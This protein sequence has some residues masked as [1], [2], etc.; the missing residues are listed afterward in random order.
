MST[1]INDLNDNIN[2]KWADV[3]ALIKAAKAYE[4][5]DEALYDVICRS[6]ILFISAH[7]ESFVKDAAK[8]AIN[9]IN[10][11][12]NFKKAPENIKKIYCK[13][14]TH[15]PTVQNISNLGAHNADLE[16]RTLKLIET[17]NDFDIKFTV[18]PFLINNQYGNNQKNPTPN[19]ISKVFNN[20]GIKNVFNWLTNSEFE[21]LFEGTSSASASIQQKLDLLH[22]HIDKQ[23]S[24]FPYT[25][26]LNIINI[27]E[28]SDRLTP[29]KIREQRSFWETFLDELL[30]IRHKIAHGSSLEEGFS[31]DAIIDYKQ[32][33]TILEKMLILIL[34]HKICHSHQ[35]PQLSGD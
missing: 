32:K 29:S 20:F 9:D 16:Q 14:F 6:S 3:E 22:A 34:C 7:L 27:S 12:S 33:V 17:L 1:F 25:V 15:N 18:E 13:V 19:I 8:A 10:K 31:I 24:E 26:D 2:T 4:H 21:T 5:S 23:T 30:K 35:I 28:P 11:F